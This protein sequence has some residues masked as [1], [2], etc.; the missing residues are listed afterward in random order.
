MRKAEAVDVYLDLIR[1]A[2]AVIEAMRPGALA[3]RGITFE[4][5]QEVNPKIV[6]CSISGYGATGP[7]KDMPSHGIAYDTWPARSTPRTTRTGSAT[8]A[9]THRW[10]STPGRS[11]ALGILGGIL[12]ARTTGAGCQMEIAQ[13]DAAAYMDWYRI[14]SYKAYERS[15]SE[16]TGTRPTTTSV[17]PPAPRG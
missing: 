11:W 16:V 14:E 17:A 9:S 10:A 7:Y 15:Q 5:M 12:R 8:S 1:G 6:F 13:S 2:D 3:R 4:R